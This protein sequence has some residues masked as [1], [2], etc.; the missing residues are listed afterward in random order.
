MRKQN[1][2][3]LSRILEF[4]I[5]ISKIYKYFIKFQQI[6]SNQAEKTFSYCVKWRL[7]GAVRLTLQSPVV[8]YVPPALIIN[9]YCIFICGFCTIVTVMVV[10]SYHL[11]K[12]TQAANKSIY[13]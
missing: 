6:G 10:V 11:N 7:Y 12:V 5:K 1:Q 4:L 13:Q 8:T 3:L 2:I 9:N